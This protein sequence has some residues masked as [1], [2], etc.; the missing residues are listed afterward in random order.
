M[1]AL[2]S[3]SIQQFKKKMCDRCDLRLHLVQV[4]VEKYKYIYTLL[5]IQGRILENSRETKAK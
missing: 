3:I 4:N 2:V 5:N 1:H